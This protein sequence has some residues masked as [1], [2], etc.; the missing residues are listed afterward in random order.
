MLTKIKKRDGRQANFEIEKISKAIFKAA[1][2]VGGQNYSTSVALAEEVEACL[3]KE[4]NDIP[5]VEQ[6]QDLVEKVLIEKGHAKTA[7]EYILYRAER[8]RVREMNTRLM[9]VFEDLTFKDA[10]DVD[11]KRE[12][13]NID[14]D[15]AM[16]TMLKY[17]SESAKEFYDL[18]VLNPKH[19]QAHK[20]GDIHIHDLD[21][22]TLTTTCCQIDIE[23]LFKGGFGTGHG[24]LREPTDIRSYSALACIAIQANQNDQ[25]GGQSVPNFDYGMAV[26]V[27]KTYIK[28]YRKNLKEAV[29]FLIDDDKVLNNLDSIFKSLEEEKLI[30]SMENN[31]KY[32]SKEEEYLEELIEDKD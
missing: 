30:P 15:T 5:T 7:K 31:S 6:I 1:Q 19:S 22:L 14:G 21:F 9:Q 13:A 28:E 32:L 11:I 16:G 27:G 23:D 8:S 10:K 26:G 17:G 2:A 25:H 20:N 24:F 29:E 3:T 12:N 18:F 4:G